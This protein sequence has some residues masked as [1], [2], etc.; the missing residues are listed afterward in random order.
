MLHQVGTSRHFHMLPIIL[1]SMAG[2]AVPYF[3]TLSN[4]QRDFQNTVLNV[5][6]VF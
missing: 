4:K 6:C 2:P 1:S 5:K 3:S